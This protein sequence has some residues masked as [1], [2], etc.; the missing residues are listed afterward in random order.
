[1]VPDYDQL[2]N[3]TFW[4]ILS[5][6][7]HI[8]RI[9]RDFDVANSPRYRAGFAPMLFQWSHSHMQ[10]FS[11]RIPDKNCAI[12]KGSRAKKSRDKKNR[13][14]CVKALTDLLHFF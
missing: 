14:M 10:H 5:A 7:T 12:K 6:L 2:A 9:R 3:F 11:S 4:V 1:M 13:A 8:T